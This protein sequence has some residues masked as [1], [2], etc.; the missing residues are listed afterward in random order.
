MPRHRCGFGL[1]GPSPGFLVEGH[2]LRSL[3]QTN[4][5]TRSHVEGPIPKTSVICAARSGVTAELIPTPAD[6][7]TLGAISLPRESV[8]GGPP[9]RLQG[10]V[11]PSTVR[12]DPLQS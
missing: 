12:F 2:V 7:V 1:P 9:Y 5:W 8:P 3:A 4:A 6:A 11:R 10:F